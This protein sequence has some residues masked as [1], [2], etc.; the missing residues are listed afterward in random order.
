MAKPVLYRWES[1]TKAHGM[2][3]QAKLEKALVGAGAAASVV[4]SELVD[5]EGV[6]T[7]D[8]FLAT[9]RRGAVRTASHRTFHV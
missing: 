6:S 3:A 9:K 2:P 7:Y 4:A 5:E 1:E 8:A